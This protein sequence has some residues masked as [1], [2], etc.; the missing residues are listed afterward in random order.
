M[1]SFCKRTFTK[2]KISG[3]NI[4]RFI[5]SKFLKK[6]F[7]NFSENTAVKQFFFKQKSFV[8][9]SWILVWPPKWKFLLAT[10]RMFTASYIVVY[11]L[12]DWSFK[13]LSLFTAL[14]P[15]IRA[16]Y[17]SC[18][19]ATRYAFPSEF[20]VLSVHMSTVNVAY[21]IRLIAWGVHYAIPFA[22]HACNRK[23]LQSSSQK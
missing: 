9:C 3:I 11:F 5:S 7:A 12:D 18:F 16:R 6:S 15:V 20:Q 22:G 1:N 4:L 14:N 2:W 19:F 23:R 21:P 10:R 13:H 8:T 17:A